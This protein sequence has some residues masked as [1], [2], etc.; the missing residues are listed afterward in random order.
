MVSIISFLNSIW[1]AIR[2]LL[3][4]PRFL[5]LPLLIY[6]VFIFSIFF[7]IWLI[8]SILFSRVFFN[9]LLKIFHLSKFHFIIFFEIFSLSSSTNFLSKFS[10]FICFSI[11]GR[12]KFNS[13]NF[14]LFSSISF[15]SFSKVSCE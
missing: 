8:F 5:Q 13:T 3:K 1:V 6:F 9:S 14:F 4:T 10:S 12:F 11:N 7:L 15:I 2:Q